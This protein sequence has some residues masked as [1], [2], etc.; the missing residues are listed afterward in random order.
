MLSRLY[1]K[2]DNWERTYRR[3]FGMDITDPKERRRS[4]WHYHVFDHAFLRMLWT[5]FYPVSEGVW[6]S[7]QPTHG[8]F[9]K[10]KEMGIKSVL[11]LRGEDKFAHYL[12]EKES[13]EELGLELYSA[14]LWARRAADRDSII[15]VIDLMRSIEKPFVLHCKSGADR[16]GF[17]SAMYQ[18]I[19]DDMP[20]EI[21]RKQ[22]SFKFIHVKYFKTGVLG[23]T[24]DVYT[25]RIARS[26]IGFENW[27]RTEYEHEVIQSG[28]ENKTPAPEIA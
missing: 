26:P 14:K 4:K 11:N 23:Y 22:L 2:L 20:V 24:L 27:I 9:V 25:A 15:A 3:S 12:F 21:A 1:H 16:A 18:M 19:F 8:R 13:C 6:R 10:Y 28:Y 17:A 7:N 5:N